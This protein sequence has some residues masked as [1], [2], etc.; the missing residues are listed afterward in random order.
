M[1][2][3]NFFHLEKPTLFV[4]RISNERYDIL[5][6]T[7]I[8]QELK[9]EAI[10]TINVGDNG[11]AT[12]IQVDYLSCCSKIPSTNTLRVESVKRTKHI[13]VDP[14]GFYIHPA[15]VY[16]AKAASRIAQSFSTQSMPGT[17]MDNAL[18][19]SLV[20]GRTQWNLPVRWNQQ[21]GVVEGVRK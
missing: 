7:E 1:I 10:I 19:A 8:N 14:N 11:M 5:T 2:K 6:E 20:H 9:I 4:V 15:L 17:F 13:E 12:D 18:F 3:T 21:E 16:A